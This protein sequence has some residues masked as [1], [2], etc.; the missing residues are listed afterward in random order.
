MAFFVLVI[1]YTE[2]VMQS[3]CFTRLIFKQ[4]NSSVQPS[5]HLYHVIPEVN[6]FLVRTFNDLFMYSSLVAPL[7]VESL[8]A[9]ILEPFSSLNLQDTMTFQILFCLLLNYFLSLVLLSSPAP[10]IKVTSKS[11]FLFFYYPKLYLSTTL[12]LLFL[13]ALTFNS[14][15][16][17]HIMYQQHSHIFLILLTYYFYSLLYT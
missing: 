11:L 16:I 5:V 10:K 8:L 4:S 6:R 3:L 13:K 2:Y 15:Q 17:S 12:K 14:L 1:S 9:L 7:V